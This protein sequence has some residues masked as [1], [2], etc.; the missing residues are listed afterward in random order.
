MSYKE[1]ERVNLQVAFSGLLEDIG[2][3]VIKYSR[4]KKKVIRNRV[5]YPIYSLVK[6]GFDVLMRYKRVKVENFNK[7]LK[8]N[9]TNRIV[10]FTPDFVGASRS[11]IV[12]SRNFVKDFISDNF[13][14]ICNNTTESCKNDLI[15]SVS[16]PRVVYSAGYDTCTSHL[17][18]YF[19]DNTTDSLISR[20][21]IISVLE[22]SNFK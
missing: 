7:H 14:Y 13:E 10:G 8:I 1:A 11:H 16:E 6:R 2:K 15:T 4:I 20:E 19:K 12:K 21:Y 17:R 22:K 18:E 9:K 5:N 3:G